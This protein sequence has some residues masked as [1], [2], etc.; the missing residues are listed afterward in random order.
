MQPA[1][2]VQEQ[3]QVHVRGAKS[4]Q[5]G[6]PNSANLKENVAVAISNVLVLV[7]RLMLR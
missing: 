1:V 2:T 4:V 5:P 7:S 3:S 6:L